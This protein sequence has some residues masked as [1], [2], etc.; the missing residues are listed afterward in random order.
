M[1]IY[2]QCNVNCQT[3]LLHY[4]YINIILLL[5]IMLA[6]VCSLFGISVIYEHESDFMT[7]LLLSPNLFELAIILR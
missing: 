7:M 2:I 6:I 4:Y 1:S 5:H 3:L